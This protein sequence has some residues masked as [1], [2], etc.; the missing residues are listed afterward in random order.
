MKCLLLVIE[1]LILMELFG[2]VFVK[3]VSTQGETLWPSYFMLRRGQ[4]SRARRNTGCC[5]HE[6]WL[7]D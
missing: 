1:F 4:N 3:T 5:E 6:S 7:A 2:Y